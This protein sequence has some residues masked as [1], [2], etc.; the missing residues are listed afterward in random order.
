[1]ACGR[2]KV[3]VRDVCGLSRLAEGQQ[4]EVGSQ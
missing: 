1:V 3:L 4:D 2:Q